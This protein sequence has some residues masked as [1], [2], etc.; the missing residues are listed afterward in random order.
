MNVVV[1][2]PPRDLRIRVMLVEDRPVAKPKLQSYRLLK[3]SWRIFRLG[4][5]LLY[6]CV[7]I[8]FKQ[9]GAHKEERSAIDVLAI[10]A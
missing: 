2:E 5:H 1:S 9:D 4:L 3:I 6:I 8:A 7:V 10:I